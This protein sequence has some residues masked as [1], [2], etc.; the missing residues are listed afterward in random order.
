MVKAKLY[1][2]GGGTTSALKNRCREGFN[3]LFKKI[4]L[5][6]MPRLVACGSRGEAFDKFRHAHESE[7]SNTFIALLVDSE[8]PVKDLEKPWNHLHS[9]PK[10][11]WDRPE[12]AN[13]DQVLFMTTCMETWIV[14]DRKALENHF[15]QHFRGKALP[16]LQNLESRSRH[17]VQGKLADA[18]KPCGKRKQYAI[19]K[20]SF[21]ILGKLD[22]KTL[23]QHL[24]SFQRC[25]R[26]LGEK[27]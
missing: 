7:G 20:R 18:T 23:R 19:G 21:E 14:C 27:L 24:P 13:D 4:G 1:I 8:E 12:R 25:E 11:Q 6:N 22:P 26:I 15:G 5:K 9:Q 17:E 16:A 3:K 2:E 10:D